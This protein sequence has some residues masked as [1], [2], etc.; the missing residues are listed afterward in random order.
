MKSPATLRTTLDGLLA[1]RV[2]LLDGAM[3]TMI[4]RHRL[5]EHDY[6]G[7]R[8]RSHP[9]DLKGNS[10]VLV[11]T[12][13][14]VIAGIHR[15]YLDAGADIIET[16]SFNGN[17][18]SQSDYALEPLVTELNET[19]AR[20]CGPHR[21][22]WIHGERDGS[23]RAEALFG[24]DLRLEPQRALG[25]RGVSACEAARLPGEPERIA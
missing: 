11:L 13:P 4:Q 22:P 1:E 7:D 16:N 9:R 5:E 23:A 8:F 17:A 15:A 6:R 19:A 2:L 24:G 14:D 21:A 12:R 3:G 20:V 10:D 18:V 25:T